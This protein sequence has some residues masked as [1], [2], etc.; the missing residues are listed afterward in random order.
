MEATP[1][2][3]FSTIRTMTVG[4]GIT[5]DLL[6]HSDEWRSRAI[7]AGGDFHPALRSQGRM[8][9]AQ[10]SQ[11]SGLG[12]LSARWRPK[13]VFRTICICKSVHG[14]K[15]HLRNAASTASANRPVISE[16]LA[17]VTMKGGA[18]NT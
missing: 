2:T 5:P 16:R 14:R 11:V 4:P 15:G 8:G 3:Q 6:T 18:S 17:S 12:M 1:C 9:S 13:T 7:T 10:N